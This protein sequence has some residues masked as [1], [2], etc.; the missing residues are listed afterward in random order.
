MTE[1]RNEEKEEKEANRLVKETFERLEWAAMNDERYS[2]ERW[3]EMRQ[4]LRKCGI[5]V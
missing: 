2:P 4:R 1:E 3:E 5:E